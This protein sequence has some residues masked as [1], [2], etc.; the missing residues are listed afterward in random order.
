MDVDDF[1]DTCHYTAARKNQL[2][3]MWFRQEQ[4]GRPTRAVKSFIKAEFYPDFKYARSINERSDVWKL[5]IGPVVSAISDV[6]FS[7]PEFVKKVPLHERAS[8]VMRVLRHEPG[9]V[10]IAND[11]TS[12][13]THTSQTMGLFE[14]ALYKYLCGDGRADE[15]CNLIIG[16]Q[17]LLGNFG[18]ARVSSRMSG[19]MNTSLGNGVCNFLTFKTICHMKGYDLDECRCVIEGDDGL[20]VLPNGCDITIE[21]YASLGFVVTQDRYSNVGSA[22]FCST[23]FSDDGESSVVD[24]IPSILRLPW[25]LNARWDDTEKRKKELANGK[26]LAFCYNYANMPILGQMA[27][28]LFNEYDVTSTSDPV[29]YW[30]TKIRK[31][32][33]G[34]FDPSKLGGPVTRSSRLLFEQVTGISSEDQIFSEEIIKTAGWRSVYTD[35]RITELLS[36]DRRWQVA[37]S[38]HARHSMGT[39]HIIH[40]NNNR[41]LR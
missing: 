1:I 30:E 18:K 37:R 12:F 27:L 24:P 5:R 35:P 7:R 9:Q 2:K 16:P 14:C 39:E 38:F 22:G 6:V 36:S 34:N 40:N 19:E 13:E 10:V 25:S 33:E 4:T 29:G 15:L 32:I 26:V 3:T 8:H 21:D 31:E 23:Y 28:S 11:H 41:R 17:T 20:F